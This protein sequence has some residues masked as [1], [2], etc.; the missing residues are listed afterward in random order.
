MVVSLSDKLRAAKSS[1]GDFSGKCAAWTG[2]EKVQTEE[3]LSWIVFLL[4]FIGSFSNFLLLL[5]KIYWV[6]FKEWRKK[7]TSIN[8]YVMFLNSG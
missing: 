1:F 7:C 8:V 5:F 6:F 3:Q 2:E 4:L